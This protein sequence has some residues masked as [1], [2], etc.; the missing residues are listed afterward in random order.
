MTA[1]HGGVGTQGTPANNVGGER[2]VCQLAPPSF[3]RHS[4]SAHTHIHYPSINWK[5]ALTD[6]FPVR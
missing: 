1:V 3:S 2:R 5:E 6:M 4:E